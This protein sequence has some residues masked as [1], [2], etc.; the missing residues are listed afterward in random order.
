[1]RGLR[2]RRGRT[3]RRHPAQGDSLAG[4]RRP[5]GPGARRAAPPAGPRWAPLIAWEAVS[6]GEGD[7]E[8]VEMPRLGLRARRGSGR[9][10]LT[11][12]RQGRAAVRR[13]AVDRV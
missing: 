4:E 11:G 5:L 6:P 7:Y 9:R 1:T 12:A 2:R 3:R 8:V 10:G 13:R